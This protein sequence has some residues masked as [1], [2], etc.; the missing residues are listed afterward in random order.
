MTKKGVTNIVALLLTILIVFVI[1]S[2]MYFWIA[3]LQV[4]SQETGTQYQ[5]ETLA[6]VITEVTIVDDAVYNTLAEGKLCLPATLTMMLQNTGANELKISNNSDIIVSD[7][8]GPICLS[9]FTGACTDSEDRLYIGIDNTPQNS[10][11]SYSLDGLTWLPADNSVG[12]WKLLSSIDF[13]DKLYM[14]GYDI[15]PEVVSGARLFKSCDM[16]N[17]LTDSNF[18]LKSQINTFEIFNEELYVGTSVSAIDASN[19]TVHKLE[20]NSTWTD[21][22]YSGDFEVRALEV[23]N[24][25]LYAGIAFNE[26]LTSTSDGT[27][28]SIANSTLGNITAL[29]ADGSYLYAGLNGGQIWRSLDGMDFGTVA[30]SSTGDDAI[31]SFEKLGSNIYASTNKSGSAS[32]FQSADGETWTEVYSAEGNTDNDTINDLAVLNGYIYATLADSSGGGGVIRSQDGA[33]WSE[34]YTEEGF[35]VLTITNYTYCNKN[36]V[37]CLRGCSSNIVPGETRTIEIK[38]SNTD[39]DMSQFATSTDYSYRINFGSSASVSGRFSKK[40]VDSSNSNS[41]CSYTYPF[42]NGDCTNDGGGT[43]INSQ[44]AQAC[45][46]MSIDNCEDINTDETDCSAGNGFCGGNCVLSDIGDHCTCE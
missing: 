28:W 5:Q 4:E 46:C 44:F 37:S 24:N 14:S 26:N 15:A 21:V 36:D 29:F 38:L 6:N 1:A 20:T 7:S 8:N 33:S 45:I 19:G 34:V 17:W 10:N 32:I 11:I 39:C 40:V 30:V 42:C 12:S 18:V 2:S 22:Y 43:C 9:K 41:V 31:L 27:T 25:K 16:S 23:F 35:G 3:K 13:D